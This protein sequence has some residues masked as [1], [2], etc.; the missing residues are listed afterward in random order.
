LINKNHP[1]IKLYSWLNKRRPE[2]P[3][4]VSVFDMTLCVNNGASI[5]IL[6]DSHRQL[7]RR[8]HAIPARRSA[9]NLAQGR[10]VRR[11]REKSYGCWVEILCCKILW[12]GV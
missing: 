10:G 6:R 12:M 11:Q 3:D 2:D 8:S 5:V 1:D 4:C 9:A 7:Y